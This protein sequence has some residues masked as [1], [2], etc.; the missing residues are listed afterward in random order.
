[1]GP[2][3]QKRPGFCIMGGHYAKNTIFCRMGAIM[4]K[5]TIFLHNGV[6]YAKNECVTQIGG[7]IWCTRFSSS[8]HAKM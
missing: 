8:T 4:H 2:I 1:M 5:S 6:Y 3:M 7:E